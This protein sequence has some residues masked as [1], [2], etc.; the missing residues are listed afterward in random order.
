MKKQLKELGYPEAIINSIKTIETDIV[1]DKFDTKGGNGYVIFGFH[2]ILRKR[3]A[4]KYYY[5]G[6]REHE[7]V[8]LLSQCKSENIIQILNARSVGE[9]YAYFM[10]EEVNG[11]DLDNFIK[12]PNQSLLKAIKI[13]RK[14][15]VGV[16]DMHKD[17]FRLLHRDLK[18]ANILLDTA[19][20][21]Y[22]A[23]FGSVKKLP[24]GQEFINGSRHAALYRPPES[25]DNEYYK[26]SDL[27]QVGLVLYQLLGGY[28]PYEGM[29]YLN[30]KQTKEYHTLEGKFEKSKFIDNVLKSKSQKGKLMDFNSLPRYVGKK[31]KK[32]IKKATNPDHDSRY[33]TTSEFDL[34]LHE[35][36]I[37]NN[38]KIKEGE[39]I[40]ID[41][42][43][44]DYK[45]LHEGVFFKCVKSKTGQNKWRKEGQIE[46][47]NE[48][49][50]I[51]QLIKHIK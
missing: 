35:L 11:G 6:D 10:T 50:V 9:G 42:N 13:T 31:L 1:F 34:A 3:V 18:P 47:G 8:Q 37:L 46:I 22:I 20:N 33:Q 45:V 41:A 15:L 48:S 40:C 25:Q 26:S 2:K 23:D 36:G 14:I 28:L 4:L 19:L 27:F 51:D 16:S 39:Y 5:F 21:P 44:K 43:K 17:E 29:A 38:W 24:E 12:S 32:I 30:K 49:Q 7:E